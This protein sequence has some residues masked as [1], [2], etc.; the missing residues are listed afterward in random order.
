MACGKV[1]MAV[2]DGALLSQRLYLWDF[3]Y[4]NDR[5]TTQTNATQRRFFY[6]L[7]FPKGGPWPA[8]QD[9]LG[10]TN[11]SREAERNQRKASAQPLLGLPMQGRAG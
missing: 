9:H 6:Y 1:I 8:V 5:V 11:V 7:D 2:L 10:N 3:S 4:R